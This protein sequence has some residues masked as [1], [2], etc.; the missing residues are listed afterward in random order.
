M[1]CHAYGAPVSQ[2]IFD[3][4][5]KELVRRSGYMG[6][7]THL[8]IL[9]E[10]IGDRFH[11]QEKWGVHFEKDER[12]R[13][14]LDTIRGQKTKAFALAPGRHVIET[15]A[16]EARRRGVVLVDRVTITDLL[17]SD[18]NHPTQ[19]HVVG[20]V[21]F[22]TRTGQFTVFRSRATVVTTGGISAKLH[23]G[24]MDNVTGDGYAL[25]FRA[26]AEIGGMEFSPTFAFTIWNRKFSTGGTG[27]FQHGGSRLVNRLGEEFLLKHPAASKESIAFVEQGD[28][29]DLCR[30]ITIEYLEGRGPVYFD[31]R[32][33]NQEKIDKMW[34]VLPFTMMAFEDAG[35]NI[36]EQ[37]VE[38]TP[39]PVQYGM[40]G[41]SGL[42]VS[43]L[44]ESTIGGLYAAGAACM[45]YGSGIITQA[46]SA[47]G[48]HRAGENA[49]MWARDTESVDINQDQVLRLREAA[50][51][52]LQTENGIAPGQLYASVNRVTTALGA[53]LFKHEKRI[54]EALAE[55]RRTAS[56]DLPRLKADDIH[57]LVKANEAR[58]F[59]LL[60]ELYNISALERKESRGVHYRE[61]YPYT[62]NRDW[63]KWILLKSNGRGGVEMKTEPV[64]LGRS[65]I[66]PEALSR[67]PSPIQYKI[68]KS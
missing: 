61:D 55:I 47:V 64:S 35:V 56:E 46:S 67:V 50:F 40:N 2:D 17:T 68:E 49:A 37:L 22:H 18:G 4:L 12:G 54:K 1:F 34:K 8:E 26:G 13:I 21:G 52:P 58:S 41:Q 24:Y 30:A 33:W 5:L 43:I 53:G 27:Q 51:S 29:G 32:A 59:T 23:T 11:D 60:M 31:L 38:T 6:D 16:Q 63:R 48:G 42:K 44:G 9:L 28:M 20:A 66:M 45:N 14:K 19:G 65:A 57:Q 62:D 36:A 15:L 25:A 39:M 7:Q 3:P 10:E